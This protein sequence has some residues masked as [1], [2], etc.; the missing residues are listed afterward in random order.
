MPGTYA[1]GG[2]DLVVVGDGPMRKALEKEAEELGLKDRVTF[3]GAVEYE[4]VPEILKA[5][6][7]A[8]APYPEMADFYFSPIKIF[9]YMA[10]GR[11]IVASRIGQIT[12]VLVDGENAL[13]VPP[14]NADAL[15]H[16]LARLKSDPELRQQLGHAAQREAR[17]SHTWLARVKTIKPLF[18][19][20]A[21]QKKNMVALAISG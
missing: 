3:T 16:A 21:E 2:F 20:L 9:E 11:P 6:D 10:A 19:S 18:V 8:V 14:G 5:L 13:L 12:D 15:A 17:E 4:R 1:D 7:V